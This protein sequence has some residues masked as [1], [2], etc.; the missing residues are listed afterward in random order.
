MML[1]VNNKLKMK[2]AVLL[3]P[4]LLASCATFSQDGGFNHVEKTTQSYIKQK[5]I[6]AN[7]RNRRQRSK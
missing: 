6:W 1:I 7:T 3:L 2:P 5:P 4:L